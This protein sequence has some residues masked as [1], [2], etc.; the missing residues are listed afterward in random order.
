MIVFSQVIA[1]SILGYGGDATSF[2]LLTVQ[3]TD[4]N[5]CVVESD[6]GVF[7]LKPL[8]VFERVGNSNI[9]EGIACCLIT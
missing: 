2:K 1:P 6:A 8:V 3:A 5:R 4:M 7:Q 9:V